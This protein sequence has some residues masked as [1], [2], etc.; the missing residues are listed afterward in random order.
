M[1]KID[2]RYFQIIILGCL[3]CLQYFTSSFS[4]NLFLTAS[5][6]LFSF[7]FEKIL[8]K[9]FKE[10]KTWHSSVI[11]ALSLSILLRARFPF[12]MFLAVG[13]AILSKRLIRLEKQHFVNPAAFAIVSLLFLY[14]YKVWVAVGLWERASFYLIGI[15]LVG[16][17][18]TFKAQRLDTSL[19][20]LGSYFMLHLGR[21]FYLG[22]PFELIEFRFTHFSILIFSFFMISDPKTT[23]STLKGRVVFSLLVAL[24]A[25]FIEAV[26]FERNGLF[27]AL[28]I[29]S[30][31][32]IILNK[33]FP[34]EKY[35]WIQ[36]KPS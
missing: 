32:I 24:I 23:P 17:I 19:S 3:Y 25:F 22:D 11:T 5:L 28:V 9:I 1:K 8:N 31:I 15:A 13:I 18:I 7:I 21:L 26:L 20:F 27:Y 34:G 29:A 35:K 10:S 6:V 4:Q 12:L 30:P 33:I 16:I 36:E 2:P 14:P